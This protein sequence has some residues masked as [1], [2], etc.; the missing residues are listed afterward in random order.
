ML[1]YLRKFSLTALGNFL[2][3]LG[4]LIVLMVGGYLARPRSAP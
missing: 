1:I 3:A 4:P 2:D